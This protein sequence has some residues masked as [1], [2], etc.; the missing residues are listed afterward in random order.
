MFRP[1]KTLWLGGCLALLLILPAPV[2]AQDKQDKKE[3]PPGFPDLEKLL[4]PGT[5]DA[6][7]MKQLKKMLE[8][9][10]E[11]LRKLMDDL[12]KQIPGGFPGGFP[13]GMPGGPGLMP[14]AAVEQPNRLGASLE[15]PSRV[16]VEQLDLPEKQGIVLKDVK[17]DSAAGKAGLKTNDILLEL[18]GK[19]VPSNVEDF[20]KQLNGI[21]KDEAVDAVVLRKGKREAVKGLKLGDVPAPVN[22]NPFGNLQPLQ[23]KLGQLAP[24][25]GGGVAKNMNTTHGPGGAFT[26]KYKEGN[27]QITVTGKV[28]DGK[29]TVAGIEI[30]DGDQ[31]NSYKSV[32]EVPEEFREDARVLI[33]NAERG[34]P[35]P[36]IR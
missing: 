35:K 12:Q 13:G 28:A 2:S 7:Q 20:V 6:E 36:V 22:N 15:K 3:P 17:A 26:T 14:F 34:T 4:P 30:R 19:P 25:P 16:L 10:Q 23:L 32:E 27:V 33:R 18:A 29:A 21:K 31:I 24:M 1:S 9:Q 11:M 8:G 5:I